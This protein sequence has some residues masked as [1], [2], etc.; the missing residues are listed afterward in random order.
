MYKYQSNITS[1][2]VTTVAVIKQ[3]EQFCFNATEKPWIQLRYQDNITSLK[4]YSLCL[5]AGLSS[6]SSYLLK[7]SSHVMYVGQAHELYV[8][9]WVVLLALTPAA[10]GAVGN[11]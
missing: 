5:V 10:T 8:R 4:I 7:G 2:K 6:Q 3:C 9:G 11:C 1:R